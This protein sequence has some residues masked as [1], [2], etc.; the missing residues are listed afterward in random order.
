MPTSE[1]LGDIVES[2]SSIELIADSEMDDPNF[3]P[4]PTTVTQ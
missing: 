3:L 4:Y 1:S 2:E